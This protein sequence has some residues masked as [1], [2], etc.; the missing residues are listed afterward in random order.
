M[1]RIGAFGRRTWLAQ[2]NGSAHGL[3]GGSGRLG[4]T[5]PRLVPTSSTTF[6]A[7]LIEESNQDLASHCCATMMILL[8]ILFDAAV[9]M[10]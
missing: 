2:Q 1:G 4:V 7:I 9:M 10:V 3:F 5:G 6:R 8:E